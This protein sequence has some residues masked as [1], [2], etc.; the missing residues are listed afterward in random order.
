M[1]S[2]QVV[3]ATKID[4]RYAE[5]LQAYRIAHAFT[6][7][8]RDTIFAVERAVSP[9]PILADEIDF[10]AN[11]LSKSLRQKIPLSDFKTNV[12]AIRKA[13]SFPLAVSELYH[14]LV[15]LVELNYNNA[16]VIHG[17][18]AAITELRPILSTEGKHWVSLTDIFGAQP[19][20][21]YLLSRF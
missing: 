16:T 7:S 3:Q 18:G 20:P 17:T 14:K 12:E 10:R 9:E 4:L 13:H 19:I 2:G 15:K 8:T 11:Q 21:D 1:S 6:I 5:V